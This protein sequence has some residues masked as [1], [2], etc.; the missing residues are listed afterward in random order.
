MAE[1]LAIDGGTK[2]RRKPFPV[3]PTH[4]E[5]EIQALREVVVSGNSAATGVTLLA[6]EAERIATR[7]ALSLLGEVTQ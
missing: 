4:D 3:W 2:L 7:E 1:P 5:R 6:P